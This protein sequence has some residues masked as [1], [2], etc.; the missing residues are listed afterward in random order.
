M[1]F[2]NKT[3]MITGAGVGIGKAAAILFAE[4][5]ANVVALDT[6]EESLKNLQIEIGKKFCV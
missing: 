3:V 5:G 2:F 4:K 1:E 6:N